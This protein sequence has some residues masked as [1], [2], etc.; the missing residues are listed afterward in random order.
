LRDDVRALASELA[1]QCGKKLDLLQKLLLSET[2][3]LHYE[4]SGNIDRVMALTKE[5][6]AVIDAIN[7][8]DYDIARAED[9]LCRI[10]GVDKTALYGVLGTEAGAGDLVALRE[11]IRRGLGELIGLRKELA[12]RLET[13]A[14][15]VRE[16][17][18]ALS[19]IDSLKLPDPGATG[20]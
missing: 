20:R 18:Q 6:G 4:K 5:D 17:I 9:G 8:V 1:L 7:L 16:S 11:R 2:D 19:R 12:A 10:I 15:A 14:R 3:K 13:D